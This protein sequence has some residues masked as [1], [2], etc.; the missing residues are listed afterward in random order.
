M[1]CRNRSANERAA[2][3]RWCLGGWKDKAD[4]DVLWGH[5]AKKHVLDFSGWTTDEFGTQFDKLVKGLKLN[6]E[7]K[8]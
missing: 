4:G 7:D 8:E 2:V 1:D 5:L 6:Y 3:G